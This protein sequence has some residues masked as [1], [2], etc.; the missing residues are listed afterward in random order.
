MKPRDAG[1]TIIEV[2]MA[3]TIMAIALSGIALTGIVSMQ[4]DTRGHL[5][6][7]ATT[8]AQGKL[9]QLRNTPRDE[10]DWSE[11]AH[12]EDHLDENG[13]S[14]TGGPFQR[15]WTVDLDYNS[16][17]DLARVTVDVVW[18]GGGPVTLSALYW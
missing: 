18:D 6:S 8:L 12:Q 13:N 10:P 1:F 3:V 17:P 5:A 11:G 14:V 7:A 15:R 16:Q 2:L 9:D 4:A